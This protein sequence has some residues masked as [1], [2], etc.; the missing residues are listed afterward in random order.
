MIF[1]PSDPPASPA[2]VRL[3]WSGLGFVVLLLTSAGMATVPGGADSV[4]TVREF[5]GAHV[6]V[7][8]TAQVIGILAAGVFL[9]FSAALEQLLPGW[10]AGRVRRA[11]R[12]VAAA[13]MSAAVPVLALCAVAEGASDQT[14]LRL[15]VASDLVDVVLFATVAGFAVAVA[16]RLTHIWAR[17]VVGSVAALAATRAVLLLSGSD[18]LELVAPLAFVAL[19]VALSFM[20]RSPRAEAKPKRRGAVSAVPSH[21]ATPSP[22]ARRTDA[23]SKPTTPPQAALRVAEIPSPSISKESK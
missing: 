5:Y 1:S 19:V 16:G 3:R 13:A 20:P 15:A 23:S 18:R 9:V 12:G 14:V 22:S 21:P 8:A 4:L 17:R 7:V 10:T 2:V 6:G 11:G